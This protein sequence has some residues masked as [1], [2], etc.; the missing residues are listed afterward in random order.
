VA[1]RIYID[2][3]EVDEADI[4]GFDT[5]T[6]QKVLSETYWGYWNEDGFGFGNSSGNPTIRI[7]NEEISN[8]IKRT[9]ERESFQAEINVKIINES[10]GQVVNMLID[11]SEYEEIDCCHVAISFRA[12]GGGDLLRARERVEYAIALTE[13]ISVPI[14]PLPVTAVLKADAVNHNYID[15]NNQPDHFVPLV[16]SDT[17]YDGGTVQDV[18][19]MED[20]PFFIA[21]SNRCIEFIG[22]IS[23]TS[24][25]SSIENEAEVNFYLEYGIQRLLVASY[26]ITDI[27]TTN[28]ITLNEQID[29]TAG[30]E[31]KLVSEYTPIN[32]SDVLGD[33]SF[34]YDSA[35]TGISIRDCEQVDIVYQDVKA[36]SIREAFRQVI[37]RASNGNSRLGTYLFDNCEFDGYITNNFGL[38]NDISIVN[39][40]LFKLFDEL[41]N[42]FPTSIDIDG[43]V[44]NIYPRCEFLTCQEPYIIEPVD[45][46][47]AVNQQILYSNVKVG[48][49]NWRAEASFGS[50]EH[51]SK[52]DYQSDYTV[53]SSSLSLLNDWSA[54]S[55]IISEQMQKLRDKEEIH[56]IM[57]NKNT[58]VAETNEYIS[59]DL[60]LGDRAI[61]MRITP[62][63]NLIRWSKFI[64][65]NLQFAS[66]EGNYN[67]ESTDT[68]ECNCLDY[69]ETFKDNDDVETRS[70]LGNFIYTITLD[71][72]G[73][74]IS[75][76]KGCISFEYCGVQKIAF[77]SSVEYNISQSSDEQITVQAIELRI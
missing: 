69:T 75:L 42:K 44:V 37:S 55:L 52:R 27:P 53:S 33:F 66:G 2:N 4:D 8:Y 67:F 36:I 59:S 1:Y 9:F 24:N 74:D 76:L 30:T 48:Y 72:C 29:V 61:N 63:R 39:V 62:V 17:T 10:T 12:K 46:T 50:L 7:N 71:S 77:V 23:V 73:V 14:R 68:Y 21:N 49:N 22:S 43:D 16:V 28:V 38:V 70:V 57:V 15:S 40:S 54:S 65:V 64:P 18:G 58:L 31:F 34:F 5:I 41:N 19:T 60:Y 6:V 13:T 32:P 45:V 26:I 51:N 20:K 56:W 3:F 25:I 35:S 47:R 11:F